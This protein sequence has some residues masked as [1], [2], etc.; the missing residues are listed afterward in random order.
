MHSEYRSS[1]PSGENAAVRRQMRLLE[2]AGHEV[3]EVV[4]RSDQTSRDLLFPL[5]AGLRTISGVGP[6]PIPLLN[7]FD[8]DVIHVHNLFPNFGANWMLHSVFPIVMTVHNFRAVCASAVL[9]R[10]GKI[11]LDCPSGRPLSALRHGC[12][13]DSKLATLPL[14]LRNARGIRVNPEFRASQAVVVMN[15]V[16]RDL[17]VRF[18]ANPEKIRVVPHSVESPDHLA[19]AHVSQRWLVAGRLS[20]EKGVRELISIWPR[21]VQLDV[22]GTGPEL[23][24]IRKL[25]H[26]NVRLLGHLESRVLKAR[27]PE[28]SG[29]IFPSRSFESQGLM[30]FEALSIGLPVV[31]FEDNPVA[32]LVVSEHAGASFRNRVSLAS[33]LEAVNSNRASMSHHARMLYERDYTDATWVSRIERVYAEVIARK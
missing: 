1:S 30:A 10:D 22:A 29:L 32:P 26:P 2:S 27:L 33:A 14:A 7:S 3:L 31:A 15:E 4:R 6:S 21:D 16:S 20:P 24:A 19:P 28:Y 11:C 17:M 8:P 23:G 25:S 12:Y 9:Y 18:G 13:R 5:R